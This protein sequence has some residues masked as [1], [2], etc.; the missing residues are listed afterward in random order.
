MLSPM[1]P[2]RCG[3]ASLAILIAR[4]IRMPAI[5]AALV[6]VAA[7]AGNEPPAGKPGPAA[8]SAPATQ[9]AVEGTIH[10]CSSCHGFQG[11]SISPTFP[12]LAGQQKDYLVAQLKAFRD[13]TRADPHA[14]TYMWGMA[15]HLSDAT[16]EGIAAYYSAQTPVAGV[17]N[18]SPDAAA[19]GKIFA[20]GIPSEHVPACM[21]C[22][23][24]KAAGM[25]PIPRLAGQ[26][27][28]Y[29]AR[30]LAAFASNARANP[31]M[32][33]NSKGLTPEQISEL[34]A[35]IATQ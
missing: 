20:K 13:K 34:S 30:Q 15:A 7:C 18:S 26:H 11:R 35:F 27:S 14:K 4:M 22:H 24:P 3:R 16:I 2:E 10:V 5:I 28:A 12:R 17:P 1:T 31:I 6:S 29:I 8:Q 19:G 21:G 25:G 33:A 9:E 32:H 23:G